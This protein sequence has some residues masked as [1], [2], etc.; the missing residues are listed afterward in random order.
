MRIWWLA[1]LATMAAVGVAVGS[2]CSWCTCY[3]GIWPLDGA[4]AVSPTGP[5]TVQTG[6]WDREL[7]AIG[8][9]VLEG[10]GREVEVDVAV[11]GDTATITPRE[12]LAP[13]IWELRAFDWKDVEARTQGHHTESVLDHGLTSATS[14]FTVGPSIP[15]V[16]RVWQEEEARFVLFSEPVDPT[17]VVGRLSVDGTPMDVVRIDDALYRLEGDVLPLDTGF[18]TFGLDVADGIVARS[19]TEVASIEGRGMD[20]FSQERAQ[21]RSW[22]DCY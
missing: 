17:T 13:G 16:L 12:P 4:T 3:P 14:R 6:Q 9:V 2:A 11:I 5:F 19:G 7:E 8:M 21:G 15:R 22:C 20:S 10:D 18:A 1:A